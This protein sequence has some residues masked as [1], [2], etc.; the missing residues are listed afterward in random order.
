[1]GEFSLLHWGI[2]AGIGWVLYRALKP[3]RGA[4]A[5]VCLACGT[6]AHP[7]VVT[8]GS[9]W[10]EL[11]LWLCLLVPGLVYSLW[12]HTTR[13]AA[14]AQCGATNLVPPGTPAGQ[15]ALRAFSGQPGADAR[16]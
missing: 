8:R 1:M 6:H 14:C 9:I 5:L 3:A 15:Q 4:D 7:K 12:R 13:H 10:I 2:L 16:G 11:V